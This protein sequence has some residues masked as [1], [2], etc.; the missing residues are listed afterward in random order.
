MGV[1]Y[2]L[3]AIFIFGLLIFVHEA[4]H[5]LVAKWCGVQINEF[6]IGMGPKIFSKV[7]K[8][9][10]T[11]Y[12]IRA[13]P[14]GG[15]VSML[16][17]DEA[18]ESRKY[19][20][21]EKQDPTPFVAVTDGEEVEPEEGRNEDVPSEEPV[22]DEEPEKDQAKEKDPRAYSSKKVWQ[23]VLI[24]LAG[25]AVNILLG[26]ICM[27]FV[28]L[29]FSQAYASNVVAVFNEE[30]ATSNVETVFEDGTVGD[31]LR[32]GDRIV[33]VGSTPVHTGSEVVYEIMYKGIKPLDLTVV[34]DGERIVLHKV[35]FPTYTD[36]ESGM[37]FADYDF[38]V[39]GE[40]KNFGNVIKQSFWQSVSTVKMVFDSIT[41]LFT[42]R[43]GLKAVSGPVGITKTIA[44]AASTSFYNVLYLFTVISI[45]L[46]V[47]NMLPIPALDGSKL[48]FLAIEG[49][50]RKP[51][52]KEVEGYIHLAGM[53]VLLLFM[54]F[55]TI[56][57]ITGLFG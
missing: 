3:L 39:Y 20:R 47:M 31:A 45:N 8:K 53:A 34:R 23:R 21:E 22:T 13:F 1:L 9:S 49:I 44:D 30:G 12:S 29:F 57:D 16:G 2:V 14:I 38:K 19:S 37:L 24:C 55:I 54:A 42:G 52:R 48:I 35:V 11:R 17:E 43:V 33:K 56:K 41:G 40:A 26:F 7:S 36:E 10:G 32:V 18:P 25:P 46:G 4:G 5:F 27:F 50:R 51:V 6:A 15:Y 28:V